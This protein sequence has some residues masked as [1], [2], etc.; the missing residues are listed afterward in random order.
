MPWQADFT[1]QKCHHQWTARPE[2]VACPKCGNLYVF[3]CN[4]QELEDTKGVGYNSNEKGK[5]RGL[6]ICKT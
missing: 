5:R 3:W 1:C 6:S 2:P 4:Y